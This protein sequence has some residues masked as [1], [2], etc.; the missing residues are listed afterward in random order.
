MYQSLNWF[1]GWH[2]ANNFQ[3][4]TRAWLIPSAAADFPNVEP[5]PQQQFHKAVVKQ[6][7]AMNHLTSAHDRGH[8]C[9]NSLLTSA[10]GVH[11]THMTLLTRIIQPVQNGHV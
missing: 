6:N 10:E 3:T 5:N 11:F 9:S 2:P 7:Y 8:S 1:Q 4:A